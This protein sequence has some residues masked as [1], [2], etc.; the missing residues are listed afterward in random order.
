MLLENE[1][2][3]LRAVEPEDLERLYA[4]ENNPQLWSAGNTRNPYSRFVLRQ[5][6]VDS[7][8][9]IYENKQLR[10][11]IDSIKTGETVGTVDLFDFD[12]H[13]S[14]IALG[15][16][17]DAASQGKG[18]AKKSLHLVEEYVFDYLKINQLYCHIAETNIPSMRMFEQEEYEKTGLLKDWIKTVNGFENIVVFQ[19]FKEIYLKRK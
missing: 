18:Y 1:N 4:W 16:F 3:R 6:I 12:I 15:L 11:M 5:Y 13:N 17:V 8:K 14:R 19:Q 9:D 2:I 10:L 7:D